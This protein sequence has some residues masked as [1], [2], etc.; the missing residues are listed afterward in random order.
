MNLATYL[1][2]TGLNKSAFAREIG[3]SYAM[4]YQFETGRRP[5]P[6]KYCPAIEKATGGLV[7]RQELRPKDWHQNWPE[8]VKRRTKPAAKA[9]P[10]H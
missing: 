4:L 8:L 3:I 6:T 7:T 5:V 10:P 9:E 1:Q 2:T